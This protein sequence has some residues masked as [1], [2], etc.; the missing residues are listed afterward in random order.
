MALD[1]ASFSFPSIAHILA[2]NRLVAMKIHVELTYLFQAISNFLPSQNAD[3][4]RPPLCLQTNRRRGQ[5]DQ[6][7]SLGRKVSRGRKLAGVPTGHQYLVSHP[8][9]KKTHHTAIGV[10]LELHVGKITIA[11]RV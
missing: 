11:S 8:I 10:N 6:R 9:H 3:P 7:R 1:A 2:L 5:R 4:I